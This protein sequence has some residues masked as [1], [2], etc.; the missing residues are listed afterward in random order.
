[1]LSRHRFIGYLLASA[2]AVTSYRLFAASWLVLPPYVDAQ[3]FFIDCAFFALMMAVVL[4]YRDHFTLRA[5]YYVALTNGVLALGYL[6]D[7]LVDFHLAPGDSAGHSIAYNKFLTHFMTS[8]LLIAEAEHTRIQV[9]GS[10]IPPERSIP[11][12]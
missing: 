2:T 9:S 12:G 5:L 3:K 7:D 4:S 11:G 1:M 6:S 8:F 10:I